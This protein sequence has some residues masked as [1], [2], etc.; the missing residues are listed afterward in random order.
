MIPRSVVGSVFRTDHAPRLIFFDRGIKGECMTKVFTNPTQNPIHKMARTKGL[1][2]NT[3]IVKMP[4]VPSSNDWSELDDPS[5]DDDDLEERENDETDE[6]DELSE[7]SPKRQRDNDDDNDDDDDDSSKKR[8]R[9][10]EPLAT[11]EN[12]DSSKI[13]TVI[14]SNDIAML[15]GFIR[16]TDLDRICRQFAGNKVRIS[17][18]I[19]RLSRYSDGVAEMEI[20]RIERWKNKNFNLM[21]TISSYAKA[22]TTLASV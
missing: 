14:D 18:S 5:V 12:V 13:P 4:S 3:K 16:N 7:Q 1:G 19:A 20:N 15:R 10:V 22:A 6:E 8:A 9:V 17:N 11:N 21:R 2:P